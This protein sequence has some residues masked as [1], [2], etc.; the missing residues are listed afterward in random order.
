MDSPVKL[1]RMR[2]SLWAFMREAWS[3]VEPAALVENWH[4]EALC[5]FAEDITRGD[6]KR[7]VANLPPGSTK[8]LLFGVFWPAWVW[9]KRPEDSWQYVSADVGLMV[10]RGEKLIRLL[11]SPWYI[12]RFGKRVDSGQAAGN[13]K[14]LFGGVCYSTSIFG[15]GVGHHCR[16]QV[17]DDPVKPDDAEQT[18][19][20]ALERTC[21]A[22][23]NTFASRGD[24]QIEFRRLIVMQRIS[25]GDP[26]EAALSWGWSGLRFPMLY[27][28]G[29]DA[30]PRDRR[31]VEGEALDVRRFPPAVIDR[32]RTIDLSGNEDTWETQYQQRPAVKGGAIIE[33][34]WI[35]LHAVS[36]E[37]ARAT[38]GRDLQSWDFSFKGEE[39]SDFVAG[40]WWRAAI[41]ND[42][43]E[44]FLLDSP[45]FD[46][47]SFDRSLTHLR[48]RHDDW[49]SA[50]ALFEDK[51]NGTGLESMLKREFPG[52]I[53]LVEPK[54]SKVARAHRTAPAW[55][56][57]RAHL[58]KGPHYERMKRTFSRFPRVRRDD[59]VDAMTQVV[60]EAIDMN[61]MAEKMKRIREGMR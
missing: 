57:G 43:T 1:E 6:I 47:M 40:Q 4:L 28:S 18:S 21:R 17:F 44:L 32:I 50:K 5:E 30:D 25:E 23:Q 10:D 34:D 16:Y 54:G 39:S 37:A 8:T 36:L 11:S 7:A 9:I 13:I 61:R 20:V 59:E 24:D 22:I 27:E 48:E 3:I 38:V 31:T 29:E 58:C 51:A 35:E 53:K 12:E 56:T 14:N 49:P 41:V 60:N 15:K 2:R 52:W 55:R 19:G 33:E 42:R 45:T 46:R 26:A